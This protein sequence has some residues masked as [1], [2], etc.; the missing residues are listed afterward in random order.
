MPRGNK[1]K[2]YEGFEQRMSALT[3]GVIVVCCVLGV[4]LW[5]LQVVEGQ[6]YAK[7]AE[8][9]RLDYEVLKS[10][11]GVIYG[12]DRNV[13]LADNRAASDLMLTPAL[14]PNA[15]SFGRELGAVAE[16]LDTT[17]AKI[18][19]RAVIALEQADPVAALADGAELSER[20]RVELETFLASVSRI[21]EVCAQLGELVDINADTLFMRVADAIRR[22]LPYEQILVKEDISRTERM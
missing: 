9:N 10:P 6:T 22:K 21:R 16:T 17:T 2:R 8:K 4:R 19:D 11:R 14:L 12:R 7:A 18:L 5:Q 3:V 20:E 1:S 13:V 15:E